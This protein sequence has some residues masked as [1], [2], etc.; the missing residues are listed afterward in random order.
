MTIGATVELMQ[1][2][3]VGCALVCVEDAVIG[4][5]TE[6]DLMK[7]VLVPRL[8]P[9]RPVEEVMTPS[10]ITIRQTDTIGSVI[11]IMVQGHYRHLPVI[12]ERA[13]PVGIVSVKHV[14]AYLV[15]HF[16]S[17]V[18]NLPPQPRQVQRAREGA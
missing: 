8:S 14:V 17:A 5:F 4:I 10:P 16:P 3:R 7:R 2:A 18:Y 1:E 9:S 6:R 11:R 12:D 15:D 13:V